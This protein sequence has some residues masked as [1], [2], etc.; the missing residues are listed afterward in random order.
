MIVSSKL[1]TRRELETIYGVK[2]AFDF[3]EIICVDAHNHATVNN[4]S[5]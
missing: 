4:P 1:A 5:K 2:D 3:A